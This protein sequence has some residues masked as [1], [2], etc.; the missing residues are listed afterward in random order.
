MEELSASMIVSPPRPRSL[1]DRRGR[2]LPPLPLDNTKRLR[3]SCHGCACDDPTFPARK[4]DTASRGMQT[5]DAI[6]L[7]K[8]DCDVAPCCFM[9]RHIQPRRRLVDPSEHIHDD[10]CDCDMPDR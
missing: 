3:C 2:R 6:H 4:C 9:L 5:D 1:L 7:C 10:N 8:R